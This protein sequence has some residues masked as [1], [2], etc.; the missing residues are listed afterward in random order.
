L[1]GPEWFEYCCVAVEEGS[2]DP[3]ATEAEPPSA[4]PTQQVIPKPPARG[5]V[6]RLV[7]NITVVVTVLAGLAYAGLH[8]AFASFYNHFGVTPEDVGY[9]YGTV[10]TTSLPG[11]GVL[12]IAA[13]VIG[14]LWSVLFRRRTRR[15]RGPWRTVRLIYGVML[16][17]MLV[18]EI[19]LLVALEVPVLGTRA[20]KGH[21]VNEYRLFGVPVL[22]WSVR[23]ASVTLATRDARMQLGT[24][25]HACVMYLGT[26]NSTYVLYDA[27]ARTAV[28]VPTAAISL[29]IGEYAEGCEAQIKAKQGPLPTR[30]RR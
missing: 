1:I 4:G 30:F 20:E 2:R 12:I 6:D 5:V 9:D 15:A 23:P 3:P 26:N 14:G 17:A 29:R 24:L 18:L 21:T 19:I 22:P 7:E 13:L 10:L 28:R 27:V 25:S 11:L 16:P 8:L